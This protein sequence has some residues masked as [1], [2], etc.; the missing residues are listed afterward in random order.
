MC[1]FV[2]IYHKDEG[3]LFDSNLLDLMRQSIARRGP[4][5]SG[6]HVF[7]NIAMAHQRLSIVD[8][9]AGKQPMLSNDGL[10]CL[11]YNGEIY[12]YR[13]IRAELEGFG[14]V[15]TS[16]SDTEVL[17][18]SCSYWGP[19]DAVKRFNGMFAFVL[20]DANTKQL[21][22]ARDRY[23]IKPLF[24][25]EGRGGEVVFSSDIK[26][27]DIYFDRKNSVNNRAIDSFLTLGYVHGKMTF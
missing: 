26:A 1:G 4:D 20:W 25:A 16:D 14:V 7:R 12:N 6:V 13:E 10:Q 11:V 27:I 5:E 17:L 3:H 22:A 2:A 9:K 19:E 21:F 23:G 8:A 24:F 18:K 15:F